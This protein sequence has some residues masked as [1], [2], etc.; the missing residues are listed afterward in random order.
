M[1]NFLFAGPWAAVMCA[2]LC[3]VYRLCFGLAGSV[4]KDIAD[5]VKLWEVT[6]GIVIEDY[7]KPNIKFPF[8]RYCLSGSFDSMIRLCFGPAGS[9]TK[10]TADSVKLWEVTKGIVIE[11]YGK[12]AFTFLSCEY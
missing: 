1:L 2:F 7:G 11:D 3:C 5:S 10:D 12:V 4:T 9:V 8:C 6:R